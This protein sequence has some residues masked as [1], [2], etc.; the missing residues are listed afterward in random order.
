MSFTKSISEF[1]NSASFLQLLISFSKY[2]TSKSIFKHVPLMETSPNEAIKNNTIGTF[3]VAYAA[4]KYHTKR[5]VF[6]PRTGDYTA[7]NSV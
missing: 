7:N 6:K 1:K 4:V 3:K 2:A 5:F